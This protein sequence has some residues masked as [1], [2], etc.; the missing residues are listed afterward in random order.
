MAGG[1]GNETD[2]TGHGLD[3]VPTGSKLAE[4]NSDSNAPVGLGRVNATHFA[5]NESESTK[6]VL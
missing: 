1:A 4:M 3:G 6:Q 2:A 5:K